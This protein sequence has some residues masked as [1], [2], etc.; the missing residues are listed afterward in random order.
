[1][2]KYILALGMLFRILF[3]NFLLVAFG[4]IFCLLSVA[5]NIDAMASDFKIINRVVAYVD[6]IAIT[7]EDFNKEVLKLR[8]KFMD[9]KNEEVLNILI[10]RTL[11]LKKAKEFFIEGRDEEII[12]SYIELKVKSLIIIPETKIKEYYEQNKD[13]FKE[14]D[15]KVVRGQ[16]ERYLFEKELNIKLKE[17]IEE[18]KQNAE[19][20]IVFIP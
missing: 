11:L 5:I 9:I 3:G 20:K 19:V 18:L 15:Y 16:I 8:E 1:M 2:E 4:V 14:Q 12:N 10:N 17:H 6:N 13:K 7:L